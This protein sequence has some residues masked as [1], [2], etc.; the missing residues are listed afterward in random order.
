MP[1]ALLQ[2][3]GRPPL[4]AGD[5]E[6]PRAPPG[7]RRRAGECLVAI[8]VALGP[9]V[10][11]NDV[12]A[13]SRGRGEDWFCFEHPDRDRFALATVGRA[14]ALDDR[15]AG[16]FGRVAARWRALLADAPGEE[17]GP[18]AVGGFA[19][20]PDGGTTPHWAGFEPASLHVPEVALRAAT[21]CA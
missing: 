11:P 4:A 1:S 9:G 19:F 2:A 10:D 8:T 7:V 15:G 17:R 18:V 20:A 5:R 6:R 13:V 21:T 16:R 14:A 3:A 12:A